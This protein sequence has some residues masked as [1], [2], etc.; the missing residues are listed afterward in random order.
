MTR[1]QNEEVQ[2]A[3][4]NTPVEFIHK[5]PLM[6]GMADPMPRDNQGERKSSSYQ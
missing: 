2:T 3:V 1:N 4:P 6:G 5:L